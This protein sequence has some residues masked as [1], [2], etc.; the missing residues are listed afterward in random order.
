METRRGEW[1]QQHR[2]DRRDTVLA[3]FDGGDRV[4]Q[5]GRDGLRIPQCRDGIDENM[6]EH[7]DPE[8]DGE[9]WAASLAKDDRG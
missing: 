7:I 3:G 4:Q 2:G 1:V 8:G 6:G 5:E 9:L